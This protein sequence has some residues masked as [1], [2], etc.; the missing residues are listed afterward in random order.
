M[1]TADGSMRDTLDNALNTEA[2]TID[3]IRTAVENQW[4][5]R[6]NS[7]A[8]RGRVYGVLISLFPSGQR[9]ASHPS[10]DAWMQGERYGE[11]VQ[12]GRLTL[13]VSVKLD[14]SGKLRRFQP[15]DLEPIDA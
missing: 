8:E 3:E 5:L 15:R 1:R 10:T 2:M 13:T 11:V 6:C 7:S 14:K 4:I 12:V 9:V